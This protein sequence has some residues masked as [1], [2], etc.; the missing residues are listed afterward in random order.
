MNVSSKQFVKF[1]L[2]TLV[3]D[4]LE[5]TGLSPRCLKLEITESTM[6]ENIDYVAT[7]ME[8]LKLTGVKLSIDDFGTGFSSLSILHRFPLDIL[9]I[10]RSFV[11]QIK[12]A[13]VIVEVVK[14]IVTLAQSLNLDII[15]EGVET[16]EQLSQLRH[17][18]CQFGQGYCFAMPLAA[19]SVGELLGVQPSSSALY[20]LLPPVNPEI[21]DSAEYS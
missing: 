19:E 17:L 16:I 7:L 10:D 20:Y 6:V 12:D 21:R 18:G 5:E 13:E 9:K 2:V 3:A 4:T 15:A 11:A 8:Q 14:T 1:D